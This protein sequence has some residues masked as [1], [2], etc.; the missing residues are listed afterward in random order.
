[1]L[2]SSRVARLTCRWTSGNLCVVMS[3]HT[4]NYS[5]IQIQSIHSLF[6]SFYLRLETYHYLLIFIPS[7]FSVSHD[8]WWIPCRWTKL[9][10]GLVWEATWADQLATGTGISFSV[11][12][13][14]W[15]PP[16]LRK[17]MKPHKFHKIFLCL[18]C[19][20]HLKSA[21]CR[22]AIHFGFGDK[23][24]PHIPMTVKHHSWTR[25]E[26]CGASCGWPLLRLCMHCLL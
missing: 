1:M 11:D 3:S 21:Q 17:H 20:P 5:L 23:Y 13:S 4:L 8:N 12:G 15:L 9:S 18:C 25:P 2:R 22:L 19:Y 10:R 6:I 7:L 26:R 14:S 16:T 24:L